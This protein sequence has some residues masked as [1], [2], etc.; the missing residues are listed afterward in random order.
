MVNMRN[1][2]LPAAYTLVIEIKA[3]QP[4]GIVVVI[5]KAIEYEVS[6]TVN[7]RLSLVMLNI[8]RD[9]GMS[10]YHHIGPSV[11]HQVR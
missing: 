6:E 4:A 10:T 2:G 8:L 9:V 11:D 5:S 3:Q 7:D 1:E